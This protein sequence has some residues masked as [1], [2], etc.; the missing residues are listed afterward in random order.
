MKF[1]L[2]HRRAWGNDRFYPCCELSRGLLG[3]FKQNC[4]SLEQARALS[5]LGIEIMVKEDR[6]GLS[7]LEVYQQKE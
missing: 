4:L 3:I 6:A 7:K 2:E 5:V 1:L